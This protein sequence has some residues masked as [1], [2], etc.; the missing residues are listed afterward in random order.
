MIEF[1]KARHREMSPYLQQ[2]KETCLLSFR[3]DQNALVKESSLHLILKIIEGFNHKEIESIIKPKELMI[4]LLD[5]IKL[6]KVSAS[7]KGTIWN[8]VGLLHEKYGLD[9][10]RVES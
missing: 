5:E 7:V 6:R 9:D 10:Y 3:S 8:L 1:L 2:I 4:M